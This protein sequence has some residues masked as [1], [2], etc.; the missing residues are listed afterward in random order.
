VAEAE[1]VALLWLSLE[2]CCFC[3]FD[4]HFIQPSFNNID[5]L[6]CDREVILLVNTLAD[7]NSNSC[8]SQN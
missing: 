1:L 2:A 6:I 3:E 4:F 5:L 8:K 7:K